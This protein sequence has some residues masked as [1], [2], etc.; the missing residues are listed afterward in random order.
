M[1]WGVLEGRVESGTD[2]NIWVE[3]VSFFV[4]FHAVIV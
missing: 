2:M 1:R 3:F 4:S